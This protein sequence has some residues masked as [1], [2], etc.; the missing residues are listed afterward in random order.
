MIYRR[1]F[2]FISSTKCHGDVRGKRKVARP[3]ATKRPMHVVLKSSRAVRNWSMFRKAREIESIIREKAAKN[4]VQIRQ[5]SNN[6]NHLH[7]LVQA[8]DRKLFKHFLMAISGRIA[9][10]VTGSTKGAPQSSKF[11]DYIPFTRIVEWGID[12]KN[13]T[14]YIIQN[15][16]EAK[17]WIDY[18]PRVVRAKPR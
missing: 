15:F 13:V 18:Q 9:Q 8:K 11:W 5:Y 2:S 1:Q 10:T 14:S 17:G 12:L 16:M 6:G 3:I 4:F 7:L